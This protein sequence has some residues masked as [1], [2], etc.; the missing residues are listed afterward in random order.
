M[1]RLRRAVYPIMGDGRTLTKKQ[2]AEQEKQWKI[3]QDLEDQEQIERQ[4]KI[5]LGILDRVQKHPFFVELFT[6]KRNNVLH[7][8]VKKKI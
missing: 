1:S 4:S 5:F 3:E 7:T 8:P 2:I 6:V